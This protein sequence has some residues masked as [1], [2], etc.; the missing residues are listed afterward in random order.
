MGFVAYSPLARGVLSGAVKSR[1]HYT[2]DDFRQR[3]AWWSPENFD[4]N[5]AIVGKLTEVAE[6]KGTTLAQLALAWLLAEKNYLVPIPGSRN[7][8]RVAQNTAAADLTLTVADLAR[9]S[10]I[11][12]D[13]DFG[14]RLN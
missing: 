1:D 11:A 9:I 6:S 13:G 4:A 7:P 2:A 14:G 10:E 3:L 8:D 5:L 12:P